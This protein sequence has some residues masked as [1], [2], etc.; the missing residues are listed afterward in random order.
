MKKGALTG[1]LLFGMFFGAGNLIFPP[2]LGVLSGENFWPAILGFV[3]SGVGIAVIALIVGTLNPKG[4]V[5]EISR[6]ISPAFATGYLVALYLAIGPFFA[7]PR[8]ATTSFE[9]G[10]APLL[11]D[12]NPS[13]WLFG[14]TALYFVAAYLIALKPSQILNSIGRILTPVFAILIVIL[15][16]LGIA[17]YGSTSP[18]PA[19]EAYSVGQAFGTG[20]I[21]GYNTLDALAAVAF[22]VVAVNTLK[23]LG[24]SSK[25]EY[26]STI[27]SVGLVVALAFSALYVGLAFLGNHF[28]VPADVL[29]SDTNKGVYILSQ[30]TQAIFGPS[31]QIF[32]AAMVIVTCFTTTAGLIVSSGEFFAERFPRFSYK[33]YATVFTLIGFGIA[34]LGLNN[35]I[36]FSVPVLLVLYPITICIVLITIVNKFV[37]LSKPGMQLTVGVV[38]VLSLVEV[39]AGQFGWSGISNLIGALPFAGQSLSWLMPAVVGIL[40]SLFLPNKQTSESFEM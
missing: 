37:P 27:W 9:I 33:V 40:L 38:T 32:L 7:I 17:K 35:I 21:E 8:T 30:A 34:N 15:V 18:L 4:Y 16:V 11:G 13:L 36:T 22:S 28:P 3:V 14:F 10:I 6:K 1:L 26:V 29:V 25:K 19:A 2:A 12:G 20:F 23:Q 5:H 31:A 39:L 24:F